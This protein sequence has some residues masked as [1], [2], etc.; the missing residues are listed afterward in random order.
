M[1][2]SIDPAVQLIQIPKTKK[3]VPHPPL[4]GIYTFFTVVGV[5]KVTIMRYELISLI[6]ILLLVSF[7]GGH[8]NRPTLDQIFYVKDWPKRNM[9]H[10]S[11][12]ARVSSH[13]VADFSSR[14]F[15]LFYVIWSLE[16]N[17]CPQITLPVVQEVHCGQ[18]FS[19]LASTTN[20]S[21]QVP[22][23][24]GVT[25]A[26]I[27]PLRHR[28]TLTLAS[29]LWKLQVYLLDINY[30]CCHILIFLL[31]GWICMVGRCSY[32]FRHCRLL[33]EM[34]PRTGV[35]IKLARFF[36]QDGITTSM[37]NSG[38]TFRSIYH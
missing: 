16:C 12:H 6:P 1:D 3:K 5:Q 21:C 30:D 2:R 19:T 20:S 26:D 38:G 18:D 35:W 37:T 36:F 27:K 15:S 8:Q 10:D 4:N 9:P 22:A 32:C 25:V 34:S 11:L 31:S 14:C 13:S 29:R 24:P 28:K 33:E 17:S 7:I 23:P